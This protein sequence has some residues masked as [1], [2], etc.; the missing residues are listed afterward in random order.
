[1][2][3]WLNRLFS[4]T[5]STEERE[6]SDEL[7]FHFEMQVEKFERE[8]LTETEARLKAHRDLGSMLSAA[9]RTRESRPFGWLSSWRQDFV[10]GQALIWR[11]RQSSLL[12]F[13]VLA[14]GI[15]AVTFVFAVSKAILF[16]PPPFADPGELMVLYRRNTAEGAKG[17]VSYP[18]LE[19]YRQR[20]TSIES[21]AA[22]PGFAMKGT[23]VLPGAS[24]IHTEATAV[25]GEFFPILGVAP[26][27]G[28]WF[29][30]NDDK[31]GANQIAVVSESF[32]RQQ[33]GGVDEALGRKLVLDGNVYTV[34]GVMP[35]SFQF[36]EEKQDIWLPLTTVSQ[37][38]VP[39]KLRPVRWLKGLVRLKTDIS[40][41]RAEAEFAAITQALAKEFPDGSQ[42]PQSA[43]LHPVQD[44]LIGRNRAPLLTILAA[45]AAL[46][47]LA[48]VNLSSILIGR[49]V[50]RRQEL[51][52]RAAL[53]ASRIRILRQVLLENA[54]VC[55]WAGPLGVAV[56]YVAFRVLQTYPIPGLERLG[57]A[58][59]D[60][61]TLI[62]PAILL[63]MIPVLLSVG[64]LLHVMK[65]RASGGVVGSGT[66]V[67]GSL[68]LR[69]QRWLIG[70]EVAL[71]MVLCVSAA[72][73]FLSVRALL[74][75]NP[76]FRP[77]HV[78]IVE[79]RLP[80]WKYKGQ[81]YLDA[82]ERILA[83][84]R[85]IPGVEAAGSTKFVPLTGIDEDLRVYPPGHDPAKAPPS[86]AMRPVT[87]GYFQAMGIPMLAGRDYTDADR[88]ATPRPIIVS[89]GLASGGRGAQD[90]LGREI[91]IVRPDGPRARVIGVVADLRS[92]R[93]DEEGVP[94]MYPFIYHFSR[95]HA[96]IAIRTKGEPLSYATAV[97]NAILEAEKE[98]AF[99]RITT[100]EAIVGRASFSERLLAALLAVFG[101]CGLAIAALGTYGTVA[102]FL[103]QRTRD[104]G[105][106]LA[107]GARH[108]QVFS[109]LLG[110][111]LTPVLAGVLVGI[112]GSVAATRLIEAELFGVRPTSPVAWAIAGGSI[113]A[114]ALVAATLAAM[115]S[116]G[117]DPATILR[118]Q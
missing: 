24:P 85:A 10:H 57:A 25:S 49:T 71:A 94:A 78:L 95:M 6:L 12:T 64:P 47:L 75:V 34:I 39:W 77:D 91:A 83:G 8:G 104:L 50:A 5:R 106:R 51:A 58:R 36:P 79:L 20:A 44:E 46:F 118:D 2:W 109:L 63:L 45:V 15:G 73:L 86:P 81:G 96:A 89:E 11:N 72:L 116:R 19:D 103:A 26:I 87:S 84:I 9:E 41:E 53:G 3:N 102:N 67:S 48:L 88:T 29:D 82:L 4:G 117:L 105:I 54:A 31:E 97:R 61:L 38:S 43:E 18:D 107:L 90:L 59:W 80:T 93:L 114:V 115:R 7:R 40:R 66:R 68:G 100:M 113:L 32:W 1:M 30:E 99:E 23:V 92:R 110:N 14:L 69:A 27:R 112:A 35:S 33:L 28:R 13:A 17:F 98:Q 74:D 65:S 70:V 55:L 37:D 52:V 101:W 16:D 76:G 56:A 42:G 108:A 21:L 111:A 62:P 60:G 22:F